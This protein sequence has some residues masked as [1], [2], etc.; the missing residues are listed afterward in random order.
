MNTL[1]TWTKYSQTF[2]SLSDEMLGAQRLQAESLLKTLMGAE[3][4]WA[5]HPVIYMWK[6]YEPAL[7][8]YGMMSCRE[9]TFG[10]G[11]ADH[12]FWTFAR[13]GTELIKDKQYRY[14]RP[15]WM[16]DKDFIRSHR[17][18]LRRIDPGHYGD[19][20]ENTPENMPLLWPVVDADGGYELKVTKKDKELLKAGKLKLPKDIA[21]RVVN[22]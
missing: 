14:V 12:A 16:D 9:W 1:W 11:N 7:I 17:S 6:G 22:L 5:K 10:L 18:H 15:P 2:D 21:A 20:W 3:D 4:E 8:I 19:Q 13:R